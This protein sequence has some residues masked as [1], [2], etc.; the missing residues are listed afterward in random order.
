MI[1]S[2]NYGFTKQEMTCSQKYSIITLLYKK[3]NHADKE[4]WRPISL[5]NVDYKIVT[6]ALAVRLQLVFPNIIS[7]D[8]QGFIKSFYWQQN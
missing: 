7:H 4:N 8:Q 2:L 6:G 3:E 1:D 5:L